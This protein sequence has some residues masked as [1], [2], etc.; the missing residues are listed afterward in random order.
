MHI[1]NNIMVVLSVCL[2]IY[3]LSFPKTA[4]SIATEIATHAQFDTEVPTGYFN[5]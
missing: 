5:N 3:P 4:Y 2:F 1:S